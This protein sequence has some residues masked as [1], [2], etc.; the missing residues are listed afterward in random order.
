MLRYVFAFLSLSALLTGCSTGAYLLQAAGGH[1]AV[2][3]ASQDIESVIAEPSTSDRLRAQLRLV[4]DIRQFS[5]ETLQLPD[6]QSYKA[7]AD[8]NRPYVVWN[9]VAAPADSL[10]L[11]TWC[12]L[13][14]GCISYK[15]FYQ[16]ESARQL[17]SSLSREGLDVAVMG[18]P[19]YSTLGFTPDPVLNTFVYYPGGEL[20]RMI[21]HELA[22]Q[23][24]YIA[25]DTLFNESF[26]TAV[27]ELGVE[28]WLDRPTQQ[29]RRG[30]YRVFDQRRSDFRRLLSIAR[31]DLAAKYDQQ[32]LSRETKL[33]FKKARLSKLQDD[34]AALKLQWGGWAGFDRFMM[35]DLNN[36][37]LAVGALYT[38]QVP[39]FKALFAACGH[40]FPSFYQAAKLLGKQE[41]PMRHLVLDALASQFSEGKHVQG[42]AGWISPGIDYK[43]SKP[44]EAASQFLQKAACAG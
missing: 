4:R 19:A 35:M 31:Q 17:A 23:Q 12:F 26:A 28:L 27:E 6:N 13:F 16:E 9:V 41:Q 30:E 44:P 37:K 21:F 8:V 5:V 33:E 42:Q 24:V 22:H 43:P 39:A 34:Y 32:D 2:L 20:A 10:E 14:T 18:V 1:L 15:G 11:N 3:N 40:Q 7:Y 25:D 36:A 29:S 38:Q